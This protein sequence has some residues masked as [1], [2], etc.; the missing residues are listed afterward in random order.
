MIEE[1]S[2]SV[3]SAA[4]YGLAIAVSILGG[5]LALAIT[6]VP[7]AFWILYASDWLPAVTSSSDIPRA[8][9]AFATSFS[10]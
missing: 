2:F 7:G 10:T 1:Y 6:L 4:S 5:P 9:P 3:L 8:F